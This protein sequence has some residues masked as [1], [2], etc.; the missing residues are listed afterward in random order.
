[1]L[2]DQIRLNST[3][4]EVAPEGYLR[5]ASSLAFGCVFARSSYCPSRLDISMSALNYWDQTGLSTL[6]RAQSSDPKIREAARERLFARYR[7][8]IILEIKDRAHCSELDAEEIAHQFLHDALQRDFLSAMDPARGRF[9]NFMKKCIANFLND[10]WDKKRAAKRGGGREPESLDATNEEGLPIHDPPDLTTNPPG[11]TL[12]REWAR[13]LF[14][15]SL[16]GLEAEYV[17]DRRGPLFYALKPLL[18]R[19]P[20]PGDYDKMADATGIKPETLRVYW[21]RMKKRFREIIV[22]EVQQTVSAAQ[23][24]EE[25]LRDLMGLL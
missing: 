1:M 5:N 12:D 25:E 3:L 10:Y 18:S 8:P 23:G 16:A 14:E 22:E 6:V 4:D 17:G 24:W 13:T 11:T 9:R 21:L 15:L 2:F 19:E 7:R 20:E